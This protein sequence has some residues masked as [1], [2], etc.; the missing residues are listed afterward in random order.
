MKTTGRRLRT[1]I[2]AL[3]DPFTSRQRLLPRGFIVFG[4]PSFDHPHLAQVVRVGSAKSKT[5]NSSTKLRSGQTARFLGLSF[6][7]L[8]GLFARTPSQGHFLS[9]SLSLKRKKCVLWHDNTWPLRETLSSQG[10]MADGCL[11][12]MVPQ[13]THGHK[14]TLPNERVCRDHSSSSTAGDPTKAR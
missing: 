5:P 7:L 1:A 9:L 12:R 2:A 8:P 3:K 14:D 13:T 4:L 6:C 11:G 10:M